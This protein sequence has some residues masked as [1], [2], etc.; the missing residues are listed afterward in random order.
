M[1]KRKTGGAAIPEKVQP[2]F[3]VIAGL[4]DGFC[5]EH[6]NNEYADL[7]R[8]LTERLARKH[9]SGPVGRIA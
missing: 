6:L 3:E 1:A 5:R 4:V 9:A 8:K 7:C 2:V